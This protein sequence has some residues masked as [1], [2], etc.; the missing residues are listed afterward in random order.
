MA[1]S[2]KHTELQKLFAGL[3]NEAR[4]SGVTNEEIRSEFLRAV[5]GPK[6][7]KKANSSTRKSTFFV[8][9]VLPVLVSVGGY[10]LFNFLAENYKED[11]CLINYNEILGEISRKVTNCTLMCEGLTELPRISNLTKEEFVAKFAYNGRPVVVTD[12]AVNWTALHSFN[13][14]FLKSLY[15]GSKEGYRTNEEECQFFPYK[16]EFETLK[17]AFSMPKKR[18]EWK[19]EP[20]YFGWSNCDNEVREKLR[21]HYQRP[22]F[23]PTDS[24]TSQQDWLFM[25]GPGPGAQIHIDSVQRPS[26]QAQLSGTKQ[27]TLIPPPECE[28]VCNTLKVTVQ[29][30]EVLVVDTNQWFHTTK[31]MPGDLSI[32]IGAEY[33]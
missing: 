9:F 1:S 20:W 13:F 6:K 7:S 25:G 31:V 11:I 28:S 30:G 16:T 18:V 21:Q 12:A 10:F 19:A 5:K 4:N 14:T 17:E 2:D 29:K 15:D 26:W 8:V 27:W 24:E 33:D 32:T 22:Y 23:L 3:R